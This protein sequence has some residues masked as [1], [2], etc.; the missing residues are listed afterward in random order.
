MPP[1]CRAAEVAQLLRLMLVAA[2][3]ICRLTD[4]TCLRYCS[5]VLRADYA[6]PLL[7]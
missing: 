3:A 4:A 1:R 5:R 2:P 7:R 6:T